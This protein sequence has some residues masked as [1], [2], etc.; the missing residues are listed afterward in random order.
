M[1]TDEGPDDHCLKAVLP[2]YSCGERGISSLLDYDVHQLVR[3]SRSHGKRHQ[4]Y[5]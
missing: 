3:V 4:V 1:E 5:I 2:L